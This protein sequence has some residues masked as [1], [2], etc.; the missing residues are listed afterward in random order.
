M[1]HWLRSPLICANIVMAL[2]SAGSVNQTNAAITVSPTHV[3]LD[4]PEATQQ[5]LVYQSAKDGQ[6]NDSTR[7]ATFTFSKPGVAHIDSRGVVRPLKEGMVELHIQVGVDR[8]VVPVH[9]SGIRSPKPVSFSNDVVP[10]ITKA[11]CNSGACHGKAEGKNG[12]KLSVFGFDANADYEA[13]LKQGR[14]R[15][16]FIGV[17]DQSLL[18]LKA[19]ATT[20]H[21]GGQ[22]MA[23]NSPGYRKLRRWIAEGGRYD[24][25]ASIASIDRLS[26]EPSEIEFFDKTQQQLRVTAIDEDGRETCV[27]LNAQYE[28]NAADVAEV[29]ASGLVHMTRTAGQAAILIRYKDQV[30]VCKVT[31]PLS[32]DRSNIP[33]LPEDNFIDQH[34]ATKLHQ[35][36][37]APS[38]LADDATFLRRVYLD[39]IGTLPTSTETR[40]FLADQGTDKRA[41][42]INALLD[43]PE[44]ADYW[45]MRWSDI[46]RVDRDAMTPAGA[47]A[48]SRWLRKQIA[49]NRPYNEFV[50]DIVTASGPIA[51]N[52]PAAI[53]RVLKTPDVASR[54]ISQV[55]LGVRIECAQCH[56]HPSENWSQADY[57]GFAGFFTGIGSKKLPD[58]SEAIISRRGN[59][60]KHPRTKKLIAARPL[61][62]PAIELIDTTTRRQA[63]ALW[64][65]EPDNPFLARLISNRLWAHYLGRGIVEPVDD[66]RSTNPPTN[67][68]L[69]AALAD[70]LRTNKFD[71]KALTR[72]ILNSRTYQLSTRTNKSNA[73][74]TQN[75]SSAHY[76]AVAAEVLYDAICQATGTK[77]KF[78]GWPSAY[79]A[80]QIWDNQVASYFFRIFGRPVRATVCECERSNEPTMSQALHLLNSPHIMK[81]LDEPAGI[82]RRLANSMMKPREIIDE[83][84]LSTLSRLPSQAET[85]LMHAAFDEH[86]ANRVAA[87][88]DILWALL[89]SK[90]FIYNR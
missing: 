16:V 32:R 6:Q 48:V 90:Q 26:V 8:K 15:R 11:G 5:I 53:F 59:D 78:V 39:A 49:S 13:I 18:L 82:A 54:S 42:L 61:G 3:A 33:R 56:H 74:D 20:P 19:S 27:T 21:G 7:Q 29:D 52:S 44:Y 76:K 38:D 64:M 72:A 47:V 34:V 73:N 9:V 66:M 17:P 84:F 35:L 85:K 79:R 28:T 63:L 43:R 55:F 45:T 67:E 37:I 12:F 2:I 23:T 88:Q 60:L 41:R 89:N 57:V 86:Q 36:G 81:R 62:A 4:D 75:F 1:A 51:G 68:P 31:R 40:T 65:T 24:D 46:L 22:K 77:P 10:A 83:L 87:T 69:L 71:I 30:A 14:G 80:I 70:H 58:G 50:Y 25:N